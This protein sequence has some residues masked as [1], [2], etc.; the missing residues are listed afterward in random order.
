MAAGQKAEETV[1]QELRS[2]SELRI[3]LLGRRGA[4]KSSSGNTILGREEFRS[5]FSFSAV[6]MKCEKRTGEV[7]GKRVTVVD[8]L[9]LL[10]ANQLEIE[11]CVS[12]SAPGPHAF[13]LVIPLYRKGIKD[14]QS[15]VW[16]TAVKNYCKT[17]YKVQDLLGERAVRHITILFTRGD[18]LRDWTIEQYIEEAGEE[19][20]Q[21]VG[22]CGNRYHVLNN[23]NRSDQSQVTQLLHKIDTMVKENN[24]SYYTSEM[25]QEAEHIFLLKEQELN[26]KHKEELSRREEEMKQKYKEELRRRENE[27]KQKYE[28]ELR[29]TEEAMKQKY[30]EELRRRENEMKQKYK[31]EMRRREEEMKQKYKEELRRRENEMKQKYEEELRRTEEAMKQKYEEELRRRENEMKQKYKEEMRKRGDEAEIQGG[32]EQ[33][34]RGDGTK[35]R[36]GAEEERK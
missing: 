7:S 3:V 27:M 28:E 24:G 19:F 26:H 17:L 4:G 21:L 13:L 25:Y 8:T 33:E 2:P 12:L 1:S 22:K 20:Q 5:G 30:E 35:I 11:S 34:R 6:T 31:E 14:N 15:E 36:G 9:D 29:R 18:Y 10:K 23:K 16:R 32:A